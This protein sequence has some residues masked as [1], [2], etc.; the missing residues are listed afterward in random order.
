MALLPV[1]SA[2]E[3][4]AISMAML[5]VASIRNAWDLLLFIVA[6]TRSQN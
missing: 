2:L 5:L 6:Q 1:P 4:L 3:V